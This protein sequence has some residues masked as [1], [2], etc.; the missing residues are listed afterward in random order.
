MHY[1]A[2]QLP[3]ETKILP[4]NGSNNLEKAS[5]CYISNSYLI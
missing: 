1:W 5:G 4:Q 3:N 2:G